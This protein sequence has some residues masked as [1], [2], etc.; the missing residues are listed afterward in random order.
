MKPNTLNMQMAAAGECVSHLL[1]VNLQPCCED[2]GEVHVAPPPSSIQQHTKRLVKDCTDEPTCSTH[3]AKQAKAVSNTL[4]TRVHGLLA[5][6]GPHANM[7][8][9]ARTQPSLRVSCCR[10]TKAVCNCAAAAAVCTG[11]LQAAAHRAQG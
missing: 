1:V 5:G 6:Q 4:L 8:A 9:S 2:H 3:A 10:D 7:Y 11:A